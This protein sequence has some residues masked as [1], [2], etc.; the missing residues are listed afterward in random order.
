MFPVVAFVRGPDVGLDAASPPSNIPPNT[1]SIPLTI[2]SLHPSASSLPI[3]RFVNELSTPRCSIIGRGDGA[4][5]FKDRTLDVVALLDADGGTLDSVWTGDFRSDFAVALPRR[6]YLRGLTDHSGKTAASGGR[7][8][9]SWG[10][11]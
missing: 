5:V 8:C 2:L 6:R 7:R 11:C 10:R 3:S 1:S 9:R 4:E